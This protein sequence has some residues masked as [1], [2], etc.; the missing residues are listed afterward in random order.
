MG[1]RKP[2]EMNMWLLINMFNLTGLILNSAESNRSWRN[3]NWGERLDPFYNDI[4]LTL[5]MSW[6]LLTELNWTDVTCTTEGTQRA[7]RRVAEPAWQKPRGGQAAEAAE[8]GRG[9]WRGIE[10][11]PL[12]EASVPPTAPSP[13]QLF[14]LLVWAGNILNVF[15][16]YL[17]IDLYSRTFTYTLSC[18]QVY[19]P[20]VHFLV[21][22]GIWSCSVAAYLSKYH[23]TNV[24]SGLLPG[25]CEV[26]GTYPNITFLPPIGWSVYR[27][28]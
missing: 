3:S 18:A 9:D 14:S 5:N 12:H 28:A 6:K 22:Q 19:S 20:L 1:W 2:H 25:L 24:N 13:L 17:A 4:E 27:L 26:C 7:R 23:C 8:A 15:S 16:C 11:P 21:E 10:A